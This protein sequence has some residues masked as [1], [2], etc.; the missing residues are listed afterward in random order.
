MTKVT[1]SDES[2]NGLPL[3]TTEYRYGTDT[4]D[5]NYTGYPTYTLS[6]GKDNLLDS[7]DKEFKYHVMVL[8]FAYKQD[9]P[10]I[11][12]DTLFNFLA[13]PVEI[14]TYLADD[15]MDHPSFK[16]LYTYP[17]AKDGYKNNDNYN[18]PICICNKIYSRQLETYVTESQ[19]QMQYDDEG[20]LTGS[21]QFS[22]AINQKNM[23][24]E[25]YQ[26]AHYDTRYSLLLD[27]KTYSYDPFTQR[28]QVSGLKNTL[29][30]AGKN[31]IN[32]KY[33]VARSDAFLSES[34]VKGI[35]ATP[36]NAPK[37]LLKEWKGVNF[38]YNSQ[39]MLTSIESLW[40]KDSGHEGIQSSK[41][42]YTY[43][44]DPNGTR[45]VT[46][47]DA[48]KRKRTQVY[49]SASGQ[50]LQSI[51]SRGETSSYTYDSDQR[52]IQSVTPANKLPSNYIYHVY[53]GEDKENARISTEPTQKHKD[54]YDGMGRVLASYN[55]NSMS[56]SEQDSEQG[57]EQWVLVTGN[58]YD[59][60]GR[61]TKTVDA[62]KNETT[63]TYNGLGMK[64]TQTDTNGN[65]TS[66]AYD[67]AHRS[68]ETRQNDQLVRKVI[69]DV[70]KQPVEVYI[71]PFTG[72]KVKPVGY[73][74]YM[75]MSRDGMGQLVEKQV[76]SVDNTTG[77]K[78][79][80]NDT[81]ITYTPDGEEQVLSIRSRGDTV[82]I[83]KTYDLLNN[84]LYSVKHVLYSNGLTTKIHKDFEAVKH[85]LYRDDLEYEVKRDVFAYN[86]I[87][88]RVSATN[89]LGLM[90]TYQEEQEEQEEQ[91]K[92]TTI[93]TQPNGTTLT[94]HY[95]PDEKI[96]SAVWKDTAGN[97]QQTDF[98]YDDAGRLVK[99][100][101]GSLDEFLTYYG[102]SDRLASIR[103][104]DGKAQTYQYDDYGRITQMVDFTGMQ[105]NYHYDN[106]KNRISQVENI[107][108]TTTYNY[109]SKEDPDDNGMYGTLKSITYPDYVESYH[110]DALGRT[111][112]IK[113]TD[114]QENILSDL[115]QDFDCFGHLVKASMYSTLTLSND[116]NHISYYQY[117][118]LDQLT[119]TRTCTLQ[120]QPITATDYQYDGNGNILQKTPS[121][122]SV[123]TYKYNADDQLIQY[124][125][126]GKTYDLSY[127]LNGNLTSNGKGTT[128][129]FNPAG[130]L[131]EV[132]T[133]DN[134]V[135]AY[136]Y[137]PDQSRAQRLSDGKL[138]SFYY[139]PYNK[140][141]AI[142]TDDK[143]TGFILDYQQQ[144]IA[145]YQ[146]T[147]GSQGQVTQD[148]LFYLSGSQTA[149]ILATMSLK[150]ST[151]S[152]PGPGLEFLGS[153]SYDAYGKQLTGN[154]QTDASNNFTYQGEYQDPDTGLVYL[155]ARDY[156][157]SLQRFIARDTAAVSNHYGF[158]NGNPIEKTDPTGH[159][160][161]KEWLN[162][163]I[164]AGLAAATIAMIT[165][166]VVCPPSAA[167]DPE[168][169]IAL[170]GAA[171]GVMLAEAAE[172]GAIANAPLWTTEL[173]T[174]SLASIPVV[175]EDINAGKPRLNTALDIGVPLIAG[176]IGTVGMAIR[177]L[178]RA[179]KALLQTFDNALEGAAFPVM[180]GDYDVKHILAGT[181]SGGAAGYIGSGFSAWADFGK[182]GRVLKSAGI[183]FLRG[184][185]ME[186]ARTSVNSSLTNLLDGE[187]P[188]SNLQV[189]ALNTLTS[190][191]LQ[192]GEG[193]AMSWG[194]YEG[195]WIG[196]LVY[197]GGGIIL[198]QVGVPYAEREEKLLFDLYSDA[199][200]CGLC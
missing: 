164:T 72:N 70:H 182:K 31:I 156:D 105:E 172:T 184:A 114:A 35:I 100:S 143:L 103:Y 54:I 53:Q 17:Q 113:R 78:T 29:D 88:K 130:E 150:S 110:Q 15:K 118:G 200:W 177:T 101:N 180:Q 26:T 4:N 106:S 185:S 45:T 7:D 192:A 87:G 123:T 129:Q 191:V 99:I 50:L 137:Y 189:L 169:A 97:T 42:T 61:I 168:L 59:Q 21:A 20:N 151:S 108:G 155:I 104:S 117:D 160:S 116:M 115:N 75:V 62:F 34:E 144:H 171:E 81:K 80:L 145:A 38:A 46:E 95:N 152:S 102:R 25:N 13:E 187:L 18:K 67:F 89:A 199:D 147:D 112:E 32:T 107:L 33:C 122:D 11:Q 82:T 58:S 162:F 128:Y 133:A 47:T 179:I 183:F 48:L 6:T 40:P 3:S 83:T 193:A 69:Y 10:V 120:H 166:N 111:T 9:I 119:Q 12:K 98:I 24:L 132:H 22:C 96:S 198:M 140:I 173:V 165:A 2:Q 167:A 60:L 146:T 5:N 92:H 1:V 39:G 74:T 19:T 43:I 136:R 65:V 126:A 181:I 186:I 139:N 127:D 68:T 157:P 153:Q 27:Q 56:K 57:S 154:L 55:D 174:S 76:Y 175:I 197:N 163:G 125:E 37:G 63:Q 176:A 134:K 161:G 41:K 178:S 124:T 36:T 138:Q 16:Q 23:H 121:D 64:T 85:A 84:L 148:P 141:S 190:A 142:A 86:D 79:L 49:D 51:N 91:E 66:Y 131:S 194:M 195:G 158:V 14:D 77:V 90:I 93:T 8:S 196:A 52:L 159:M 170:G 28:Y 135:I 73:Y 71:Y 149:N 188:Q 94:E 30:E 44:D 109:S